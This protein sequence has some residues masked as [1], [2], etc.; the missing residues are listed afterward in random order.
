MAATLIPLGKRVDRVDT[1]RVDE[2]EREI[3]ALAKRLGFGVESFDVQE[4]R[5]YVTPPRIDIE[6]L[7]LP[8]EGNNG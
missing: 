8:I 4:R 7:Q 6:L 2:L 1:A 5:D 3:F